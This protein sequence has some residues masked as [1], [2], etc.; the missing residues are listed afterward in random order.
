MLVL[1]TN[2]PANTHT[3]V[4]AAMLELRAY[5]C[6]VFVISIH[7]RRELEACRCA[8]LQHVRF[9]ES[10][11]PEDWTLRERIHDANKWM[12]PWHLAYDR[13]ATTLSGNNS[14]HSIL[15]AWGLSWPRLQTA[16]STSTVT[17][18]MCSC[19][20]CNRSFCASLLQTLSQKTTPTTWNQTWWK[21]HCNK[22]NDDE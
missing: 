19:L 9:L 11:L 1:H 14:Y 18:S 2:W 5:H 3:R 20:S 6:T 8:R 22:I 21:T 7:V 17:V 4:I 13:Q 12:S 15:R 16:H 10:F